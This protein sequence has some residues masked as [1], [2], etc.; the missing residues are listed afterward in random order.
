VSKPP[1]RI[2]KYRVVELIG[3]GGM[4]SVYKAHDALLD[5][6]V[7]I[8]VM[9]E[10]LDIDSEAPARFLREAQ[11]V[12]RLGHPNIITVF[13][14]GEEQGR[15]FI[16]ME[17]LEGE[18]L[19][20]LIRHEPPLPLRAKLGI[21]IQ[22]CE[23]LGFAHQRGVVHRDVKPANIFVLA[24]G[25]VKILD[26]GI[27]RI[28]TSDLT[29]TGLLMGTPNYMSPEQARGRRTDTR[30]DIF[31]AGVVFYEFLTGR[32][33]F[34]GADYFE[35]LERLQSE[36]PTW[37][38]EITPDLPGPL[39]HAVHKA[40]AKGL[41]DRYQSIEDLRRDLAA[42][43]ET[44]GAVAA[45]ELREAVTRK[46]AE[47]VRLHRRLVAAV[48]AAALDDEK[49]PVAELAANEE[50]LST[51]LRRLEAQ[52]ERLGSLAEKAERLEPAVQRGIAAAE[53][54][55]YTA[56]AAELE[57]VLAEI[58]LH[59]RARAYRD[60]VAH[61]E[62]LERTVRAF[63]APPADRGAA[64]PASTPAGP[65]AESPPRTPPETRV[66]APRA[67][68]TGVV[69]DE[70]RPG[71]GRRRRY[72]MAAVAVLAV[73]GG[74]VLLFGPLGAPRNRPTP[75]AATPIPAP[76]PAPQPLP[77]APAPQGPQAAPAPPQTTPAPPE[78]PPAPPEAPPAAPEAT[79]AP[80]QAT[81]A[82]SPA[83]S[84]PPGAV[85]SEPLGGESSVGAAPA[86][87]D[88]GGPPAG[89]R[90]PPD[91]PRPSPAPPPAVAA[92]SPKP[93]DVGT[94]PRRA[95]RDAK[96]APKPP[97]RRLPLTAEQEK[98]VEDALTLAQL[99]QARGDQVRALREYRRVLEIDPTHAEARQ[100]LAE[101]ERAIRAGQ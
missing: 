33:P 53:R 93:P 96:P 86:P 18:P 37:L 95:P 2:G 6:M 23:G 3:R 74:G 47:V 4:G 90:L 52:A 79:P 29:R 58:P 36:E 67:V 48:G 84:P 56:A 63:G 59:Q 77:V 69:V 49:L 21:M 34:S 62:A 16:V 78:A 92:P 57:A 35:T 42:V 24:S 7:A 22:I 99:F 20:G 75:P 54:G 10:D 87:Q 72:A 25:Q 26:F 27:A 28:T 5:R 12:A 80:P 98:A 55:D 89:D 32:K 64:L 30:T 9:K 101:V 40:M 15:V 97:A 94:A 82:P 83:P 43:R 31:S 76:T 88:P 8:K 17:L 65:V 100:G 61:E 38:A 14:L 1:A 91:R 68:G 50:G 41:G 85:S 60:R 66:P 71:S 39:V 73:V 44:L 45:G 51:V 81:P 19:T 11:S 70:T 13:E 46:L